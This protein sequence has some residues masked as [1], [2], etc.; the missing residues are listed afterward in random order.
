MPFASEGGGT[1]AGSCFGIPGDADTDRYGQYMRGGDAVK[2]G[3]I[4]IEGLSD[5]V[6]SA[7]GG[8]MWNEF[9]GGRW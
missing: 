4:D 7:V 8:I 6:F 9:G 2:V 3:D 5:G 1:G